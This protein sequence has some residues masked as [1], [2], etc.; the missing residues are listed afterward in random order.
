MFNAQSHFD[1]FLFDGQLYVAIKVY[2]P[3]FLGNPAGMLTIS[4]SF[5]ASSICSIPW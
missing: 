1:V 3:G 2:L 4:Q 5:K